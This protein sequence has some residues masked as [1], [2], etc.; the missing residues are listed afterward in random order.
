MKIFELAH[1][2]DGRW[3]PQQ[4]GAPGREEQRQQVRGSSQSDSGWLSRR[5]GTNCHLWEENWDTAGIVAFSHLCQK[6]SFSS[7]SLI[8]GLGEYKRSSRSLR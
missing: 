8:A 6:G 7:Q 2:S 1:F 5:M 4:W 3:R